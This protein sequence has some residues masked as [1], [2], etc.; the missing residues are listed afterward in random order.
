MPAWLGLAAVA[1]LLLAA[2]FLLGRLGQPLAAPDA[3][4][5][6]ASANDLSA[7]SDEARGR[8][9]AA[10]LTD[11]LGHSERL[12]A[13]VVNASS[14]G[15][16]GAELEQAW[17]MELLVSNRVYR[18]AAKRAGQKRI[19]SLLAELEPVLLELAHAA[20]GGGDEF[21]QLRR[22]VDERGLL[23]KVRVTEQR[24]GGPAPQPS[25]ESL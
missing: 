9:L 10:A 17:A 24:L 1:V 11:H 15:L 20:P 13:E 21:D 3:P 2:G 19:A 4:T 18:R 25:T 7:L 5:T 12:L 23:F 8:L 14:S 22:R 16:S 6:I